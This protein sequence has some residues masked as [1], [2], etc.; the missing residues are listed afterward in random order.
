MEIDRI[1]VEFAVNHIHRQVAIKNGVYHDQDSLE[2]DLQ[3][4]VDDG[5]LPIGWYGLKE[6]LDKDLEENSS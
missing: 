4:L 3:K 5:K 6:A 1:L 2:E